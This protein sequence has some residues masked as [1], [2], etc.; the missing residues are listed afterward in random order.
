MV[1]P[2]LMFPAALV[3]GLADLLIPELARCSAAGSH[4][5][6]RYL[7]RRSLRAVLLYGLA[8]GGVFCLMGEGLCLRLYQN[9]D[10]GKWLSIYGLLTPM[11]Y[12]DAIID[13]MNKGLGLQQTCVR[14]NIFTAVLDVVGLYI[15][16]PR[17]GMWGYFISFFISHAINFGLSLW[18]LLY[19]IRFRVRP[20]ISVTI[21]LAMAASLVFA[22]SIPVLPLKL[23][24]FFLSAGGFLWIGGIVGA[25]DLH[26]LTG[27]IFPEKNPD[28][29]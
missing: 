10:A 9:P 4:R 8:C 18:L 17:L 14:F 7:A 16:L 23:P 20:V 1:F 6:I 5:R 12:C 26:W 2:V 15:L 25:E 11:L 19:T 29:L 28:I 22:K 24:I 27:M 21:L 3:Y 13:A